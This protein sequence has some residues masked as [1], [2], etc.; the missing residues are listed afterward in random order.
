MN[1]CIISSFTAQ[2]IKTYLEECFE[3]INMSA[4][5]FIKEYSMLQDIILWEPSDIDV[6]I[7]L[8]LREDIDDI[9]TFIDYIRL[10]RKKC[11]GV[12]FLSNLITPN[13]RNLYEY[14]IKGTDIDVFN[15]YQLKLKDFII[16][17]QPVNIYLLDVNSLATR[18]GLV[19]FYDYRLW[20]AYKM[21]FSNNGFKEMAY[22][23]NR[24]INSLRLPRRKCIVLDCDNTLWGG[25]IGEDGLEGIKLGPEYPGNCFI[26]F[27]KKLKELKKLG[28]ILAINSK[29][30]YQD[31]MEVLEHHPSQVL[32]T[33]DFVCKKIN[34]GD[35]INN[36]VEI[37]KELNLDLSSFIFI[38][39]NPAEIKL[40]RDNIPEVQTVIIPKNYYEIANVLENNTDLFN[41][42]NVTRED[43]NKTDMYLANIKR[44]TLKR[45]FHNIE[46][47]WQS[48]EMG[49]E[50]RK[51]LR[52]DIFRISQ[53]T[54]KTN[55]FNTITIRRSED[56]IS[57][58]FDDGKWDIYTFKLTDTFGDN[59]IVGYAE[60]MI[61]NLEA[62]I[63]NYLMSCRV[64][65]RNA[66]Y[67]FLTQI[68]NNIKAKGIHT[69]YAIWNRSLK[70]QVCEN[71]YDN[72][73][74]SLM[75][76]AENTKTYV[77]NL[78]QTEHESM[79]Y[80]KI[81]WK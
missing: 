41:I 29:N 78:Q 48:L 76:C 35:K 27:Q 39:D 11:N 64:I 21:P 13:I 56:E 22:L 31:V 30:N 69:V 57:R 43:I 24:A 37:A 52:E 68:L 20:Y 38:D 53:M 58:M 51:N 45:S 8:Y 55:Q 61:N 16:K 62:T 60:I 74:F 59:G 3:D 71:F 1:I 5:I 2:L 80:F 77:L 7:L 14:N 23:I 67:E 34:W 33:D 73:G 17:E 42:L 50:V 72:Y 79:K 9:N 54:Y 32:K 75:D 6:I 66:E 49:M 25:I 44:E 47:Y 26:E 15:D 46:D 36:M 4:N 28:Y 10:L 19:S 63:Y 40:I 12:I 65:S 81:S 18:M 70:N